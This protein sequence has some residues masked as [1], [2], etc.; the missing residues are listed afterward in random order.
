MLNKYKYKYHALKALICL[1]VFNNAGQAY[2]NN[3][4]L[5]EKIVGHKPVITNVKIDK[6]TPQLGET[7]TLVYDYSDADGDLEKNSEIKWYYNTNL[8]NGEVTATYL[9]KLNINTGFDIPCTDFSIEAVVT[10]KSDTGEPKVGEPKKTAPVVV[11]LNLDVIPGFIFPD[12]KA[13]NWDDANNMCIAKGARLPTRQELKDV[14]D[15]NTSGSTNIEMS[16]KFGWPLF[17]GLCGG[18]QYS[19]WTSDLHSQGRH[20]DVDMEEGRI[21]DKADFN[22]LQVACVLLIN[23]KKAEMK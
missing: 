11:K 23:S 19:Y 16:E 5:T 6:P 22:Q 18:Y 14:F 13:L 10:P 21:F 8:L 12:T 20:Y 2:A 1:L 4:Q 15:N 9:P 7:L 17:G 3:S